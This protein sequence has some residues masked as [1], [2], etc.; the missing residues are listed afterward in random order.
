MKAVLKDGT[1][2]E[3]D[4]FKESQNGILLRKEHKDGPLVGFVPYDELR[5]IAPNDY[6]PVDR[7]SESSGTF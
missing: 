2:I 4:W 1:E 5:T 3:C 7:D 6:E